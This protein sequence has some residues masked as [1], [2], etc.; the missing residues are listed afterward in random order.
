MRGLRRRADDARRARAI[1]QPRVTTAAATTLTPRRRG[2]G[3]NPSQFARDG[4]SVPL[5]MR[6][7]ER[8]R[9]K[10]SDRVNGDPNGSLAVGPRRSGL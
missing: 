9:T 7:D 2:C 6:A 1:R 5:V 3:G 4:L 10:R 8:R